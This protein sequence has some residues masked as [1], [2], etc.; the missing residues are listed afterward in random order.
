MKQQV[1]V[2]QTLRV[3]KSTVIEVEA[4]SI[5]DAIEA[6]SSGEVDLPS[7][8]DDIGNVWVVENSTLENEAYFQ[9]EGRYH[10]DREPPMVMMDEALD[11][12]ID[13][14]MAR[15]DAFPEDYDALGDAMDTILAI[16][17]RGGFEGAAADTIED[18]I[19]NNLGIN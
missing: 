3:E 8:S 7:A 4:D 18:M 6:I 15:V 13:H 11:Q 16:A 19:V 12:M 17:R 2:V 1:K 14:A 10:D 9:P 5:E